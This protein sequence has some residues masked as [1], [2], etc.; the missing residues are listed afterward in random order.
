MTQ[1]LEGDMPEK[2]LA[3]IAALETKL[4]ETSAQFRADA[5][6]R[7]T[8][9]HL[10][11]EQRAKDAADRQRRALTAVAIYVTVAMLCVIAYL[12]QDTLNSCQ[13]RNARNDAVRTALATDHDALPDALREGFGDTE[14]VRRVVRVIR[15]GYDKSEA[16]LAADFPIRDCGSFLPI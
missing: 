11:E 10:R 9:Q 12:R 1:P 6:A 2:V 4:D 15:S 13:A 16:Q 5:E 8:A 3:A 14:D 7:E